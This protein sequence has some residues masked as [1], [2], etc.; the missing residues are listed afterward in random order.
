M[1]LIDDGEILDKNEI[2]I[3]VDIEGPCQ[4]KNQ[5]MTYTSNL[6]LQFNFTVFGTYEPPPLKQRQVGFHRLY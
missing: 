2:N 5:Q 4:R 6:Q 1:S 3:N